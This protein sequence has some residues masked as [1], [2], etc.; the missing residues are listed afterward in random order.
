MNMNIYQKD[1]D[2]IALAQ[3]KTYPKLIQGLENITGRNGFLVL[4][5]MII[6][7]YLQVENPNTLTSHIETM[8]KVLCPANIEDS[9]YLENTKVLKCAC[10]KKHIK[11]LTLMKYGQS[12][13]FDL[14]ILGSECINTMLKFVG[15][16]PDLHLFNHLITNWSIY[17]KREARKYKWNSCFACDRWNIS[18][19]TKYKKEHRKYWCLDCAG[20]GGKVKC[21]ECGFLRHFTKSPTTKEYMLYCSRCFYD[22]NIKKI[23]FQEKLKLCS[24]H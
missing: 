5:E 1:L 17:I 6:D 7:S 4:S 12:G 18:K 11:N 9:E 14:I 24:P 8:G 19:T 15:K 21:I 10:G 20:I 22:P 23:S 3:S 16:I 2:I 13:N